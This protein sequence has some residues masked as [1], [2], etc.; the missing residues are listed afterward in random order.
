MS[1]PNLA[2]VTG[3]SAGIGA[4]PARERSRRGRP[5]LAVAR[6]IGRPRALAAE[7]RAADTAEF[8]PLV[9]DVASEGAGERLEIAGAGRRFERTAVRPAARSVVRRIAGRLHQEKT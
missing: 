4:A 5:V 6:R 1:R 7:A 8:H 9:L 2:S 3:V